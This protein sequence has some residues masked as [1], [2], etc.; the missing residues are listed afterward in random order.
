MHRNSCNVIA[1]WE[2][3]AYLLALTEDQNS[4]KPALKALFVA[5][6]SYL[7]RRE[8]VALH[9]LSKVFCAW[10]SLGP[11]GELAYEGQPLLRLTVRFPQPI[12]GVRAPGGRKASVK[13]QQDRVTVRV[14]DPPAGSSLRR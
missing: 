5:C 2:T 10:R 1:G 12:K 14:A 13:L 11:E 7:R 3:D 8:A 4:G 6:G 9:S